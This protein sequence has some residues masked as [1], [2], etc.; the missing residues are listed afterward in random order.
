M[1]WKETPSR[2][3]RASELNPA[4]TPE[5]KPASEAE[6]SWGPSE[7]GV[8]LEGDRAPGMAVLV[9]EGGGGSEGSPSALGQPQWAATTSL[10]PE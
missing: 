7:A 1:S 5:A 9:G 4:W 6:G 10:W 3:I 2:D 8:C